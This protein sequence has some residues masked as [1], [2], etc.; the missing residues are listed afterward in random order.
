M[1]TTAQFTFLD[2]LAFLGLVQSVF[3]FVAIITR[4][5]AGTEI[6]RPLF[7]ISSL[8]IIFILLLSGSFT[9]LFSGTAEIYLLQI[10][11]IVPVLGLYFAFYWFE[12]EKYK[13]RLQISLFIFVMIGIFLIA[14]HSTEFIIFVYYL[15]FLFLYF[16]SLLFWIRQ[17]NKIYTLYPDH[18]WLFISFFILNLGILAL[19]GFGGAVRPSLALLAHAVLL[20][21]IVYILNVLFFR[22]YP[23]IQKMDFRHQ[24][25][26]K[27]TYISIEEREALLKAIEKDKLYQETNCNRSYLARETGLSEARLTKIVRII[28]DCSVPALI[29]TKR[30]EEAKTLLKQTDEDISSIGF[31]VGFGSVASFNRLFKKYTR[32]TPS[33]FRESVRV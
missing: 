31:E 7:Y 11:L 23:P 17:K 26:D 28:Y 10:F 2:V 1:L 32:R 4:R 3:I 8:A 16:L 18:Y 19:F 12:P 27:D 6:L 5:K 9:D 29:N 14:G 21:G 30:V 13:K 15:A 25:A 33:Q 20:C 24:V 22:L